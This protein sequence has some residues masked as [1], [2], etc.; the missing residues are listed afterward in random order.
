MEE[1]AYYKFDDIEK[2]DC[3]FNFILGPRGCG[4]TI[5]AKKRMVERGLEGNRFVYVRRK[6]VENQGDALDEFFG[7][8]QS[9]GIYPELDLKVE[10]NKVYCADE[11]IGYVVSLSTSHNIRSKD[12][13]NV[14]DIYFEEFVIRREP[15][16]DY[17]PDEPTKFLEMYNTIARES[18]V[19]VW[20]LGNLI[21]YYNPYFLYFNLIPPKEGIKKWK[22]YC[23]EVWK[24]QVFVES[25]FNTRFG[26][27]IQ[28]T[29]Y[30]N[31]AIENESFDDAEVFIAKRPQSSKLF[32]SFTCENERYGVYKSQ[33]K[34]RYY[35]TH[36]T[37][38]AYRKSELKACLHHA[39]ET[40]E[41]KTFRKY[42]MLGDLR[43]NMLTL[44]LRD[45][46][47]L[48]ESE[49]EQEIFY[50]VSRMLTI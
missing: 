15:K 33:Y 21:H 7:K 1:N 22:D 25:K 16:F 6:Q 5:S 48:Y 38:S 4:K 18:E 13:L 41:V 27:L 23:I 39:D 10:K 34:N 24:N 46:R 42:R 35:V 30:A 43:I 26:R 17:L 2:K 28:G 36:V 14:T 37:E 31:Y 12:Y 45:N 49:K 32:I 8:M 19:K 3:L 44:A 11:L 9:C 29:P 47:V 20:F 40:H 50:Q